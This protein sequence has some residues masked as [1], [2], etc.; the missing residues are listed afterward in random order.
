[1]AG[2]GAAPALPKQ[3]EVIV[4]EVGGGAQA[5]GADTRGSDLNRQGDAVQPPADIGDELGILISQ[6][7]TVSPRRGAIHEQ[8]NCRRGHRLL[9]RQAAPRRRRIQ[10]GEEGGCA[11][12]QPAA[13]RCWWSG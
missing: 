2:G 5:V 11:R 7:R 13:P 12:P 3:I 1:M 4:E 9:R 10:G 6:V 8:L